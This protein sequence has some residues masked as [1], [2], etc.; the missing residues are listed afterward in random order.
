MTF[1]SRWFLGFYHV[2][3]IS[4]KHCSLEIYLVAAR[5]YLFDIRSLSPQ[6]LIIAFWQRFHAHF[7]SGSKLR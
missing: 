2:T 6:L 4:P 7:V 5:C 3:S 1:Q